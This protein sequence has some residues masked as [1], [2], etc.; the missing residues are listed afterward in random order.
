MYHLSL[1]VNH[2][3]I[4]KDHFSPLSP[5]VSGTVVYEPVSAYRTSGTDLLIVLKETWF[6]QV[7][8]GIVCIHV[9]VNPVSFYLG[10]LPDLLIVGALGRLL[11]LDGLE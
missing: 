5:L 1:L 6:G 11:L 7:Y 9:I 4:Q 8:N 2:R 3:T 10:F